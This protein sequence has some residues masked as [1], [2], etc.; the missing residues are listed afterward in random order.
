MVLAFDGV[1]GSVVLA[2]DG[3]GGSVVLAFDGASEVTAC[4]EVAAAVLGD[5]TSSAPHSKTVK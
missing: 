4:G 2:F 5:V 3:V 1:G